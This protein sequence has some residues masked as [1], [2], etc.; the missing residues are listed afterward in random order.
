MYF[1]LIFRRNIMKSLIK[2]IALSAIVLAS[3]TSIADP[4]NPFSPTPAQCTIQGVYVDN[5]DIYV[6]GT[7]AVKVDGPTWLQET[8]L[9]IPFKFSDKDRQDLDKNGSWWVKLDILDGSYLYANVFNGILGNFEVKQRAIIHG[10]HVTVAVCD[11]GLQLVSVLPAS[12]I[13]NSGVPVLP[14]TVQSF[15]NTLVSPVTLTPLD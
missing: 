8:T 14:T 5:D 9:G 1:Y 12:I 13:G 4:Y 10:K 2:S 15:V 6:W 7:G 11:S 3:A